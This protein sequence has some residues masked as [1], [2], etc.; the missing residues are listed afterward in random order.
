M[1]RRLCITKCDVVLA[2]AGV[3]RR[4]RSD[5]FGNRKRRGAA[6]RNGGLTPLQLPLF[7]LARSA[8]GSC[9][10]W[11]RD[12]LCRLY[13][14]IV[15]TPDSFLLIAQD[16][17][18][19]VGF[20]A[21]SCDVSGLYRSFVLRDGVAAAF[22]SAGR[23]LRSWRRVMETLHH[24]ASDAADGAELLAVAVDPAARGRGVGILLVNGFLHEI[25]RRRRDAAH[26]V[27]A[28]DNETAI[29][30]Y[31]RAGFRTRGEVRDASG[32]RVPSDA[33]ARCAGEPASVSTALLVAAASAAITAVAVPCCIMMAHHFGVI[34]RPGPLKPHEAPVAYLGGVAVFAGLVVGVS[35]GRPIVLIPLAAAL[36]IGVTDDRFGL[37]APLRLAAQLGVGSVVAVTVP[38]HLPGWIGIPLVVIASV[39]LINGFNLLD[40]L[41]LLAAGV[42]AAAAVGF[43]FVLHGPGRLM[44][45]SLAGALAAFLWS[46]RPPARIY[47]GDGGSYL[48]GAA[49]SVLLAYTWGVGVAA[50]TGVIAL[51]L[52]AVPAAEVV[53]AI[54]RRH[55]ASARFWPATALIPMTFSSPEAGP[56]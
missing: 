4:P 11:G 46:N 2:T 41:D 42:G 12:F 39:L 55:R 37:P 3:R 35:V 31:R 18:K 27:V 56:A 9:P 13:R 36:A 30:L 16:G 50:S 17:E 24:G 23:L 54:V 22:A 6:H 44:A 51:A 32:H 21:G 29:A 15:R 14:R 38:I 20:L 48:I 52:L 5:E 1:R 45:A 33:V 53:C 25:G 40:G 26:V 47:L 49:M 43:A 7:T 34:D 19:T 8:R 10:S 28:A